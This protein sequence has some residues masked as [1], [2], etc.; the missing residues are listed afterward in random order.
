MK[1]AV[2][3]KKGQ[4]LIL[5]LGVM[6]AIFIMAVV[7]V[8]TGNLVY[9]RIHLQ[10]TA[11][12]AALEGGLW[13][14]RALNVVSLSNKGLVLT[15]GVAVAAIIITGGTT[16]PFWERTLNMYMK[17]QDFFAGTGHFKDKRLMPALTAGAVVINGQRN[18]CLS[19]PLFNVE[20]FGNNI[21]PS[22]NLKRRT[23]VDF[24]EDSIETRYYYV[25]QATG[26]RVDVPSRE[27][28]ENRAGRLY[29]RDDGKF[30]IKESGLAGDM[31]PELKEPMEKM[32]EIINTAR[33]AP[34]AGALADL[35]LNKISFDIRETGPHTILVI[36]Y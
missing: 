34:L 12:S 31:P 5:A 15:T 25:E 36:N 24:L 28:A 21:I 9:E 2:R 18:G 32:R 26:R 35:L 29:K 30:V 6:A 17:A 1:R 4:I 16:L 20:D 23:L 13:Y 33:E 7:V 10:N 19:I 8:E 14:A 22:Y 11:D 27:V 3:G